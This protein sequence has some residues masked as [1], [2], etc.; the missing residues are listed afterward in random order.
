[1]KIILNLFHLYSVPF[2]VCLSL[3]KIRHVVIEK[4]I[5]LIP[6]SKWDM[7]LMEL[8]HHHY[9]FGLSMISSS[10]QNDI[11]LDI[12]WSATFSKLYNTYELLK[13][14][15]PIP[16]QQLTARNIE[17]EKDY[18]PPCMSHLLTVLRTHHRLSHTWRYN[19][20]LFLKDIGLNVEESINFWKNEYS[21]TCTPGTSC[22]HSWQANHKK[23]SYSIRHMYGLEG[24]RI[25]KKSK[26]CYIF[27]VLYY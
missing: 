21:K 20:S 14:S 12:R 27:Q 1:M 6:C 19:F 23:Y 26:D 4:G 11:N 10:I 13:R 8:F 15:Q 24:S 3:V 22:T 18:F 16:Q 5:A 25:K 17:Y 7:L 9:E 2:Q